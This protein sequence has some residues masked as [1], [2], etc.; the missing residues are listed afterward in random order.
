MAV[1]L[2]S[3]LSHD[4]PSLGFDLDLDLSILKLRLP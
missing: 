2:R 1:L 3:S 4:S